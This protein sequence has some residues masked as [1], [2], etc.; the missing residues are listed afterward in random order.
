MADGRKEG[1]C[2]IRWHAG[3]WLGVL[4]AEAELALQ[5]H[6]LPTPISL[7][8][9]GQERGES[10]AEES[11]AEV[12]VNRVTPCLKGP[13]KEEVRASMHPSPDPNWN[14]ALDRQLQGLPPLVTPPGERPGWR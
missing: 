4:E 3:P 8:F 9:A 11:R 2:V 6:W 13:S 1:R 7:P 5:G 12:R 14:R 10:S